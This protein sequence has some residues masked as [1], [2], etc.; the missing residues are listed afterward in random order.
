[1]EIPL[2]EFPLFFVNPNGVILSW[3]TAVKLLFGYEDDEVIGKHIGMLYK[4]T[5]NE[6]SVTESLQNA[7]G[8]G[9]CLAEVSQVKKNGMVL[10]AAVNYVSV[11]INETELIGLTVVIQPLD[12]NYGIKPFQQKTGVTPPG[13]IITGNI[14]FKK[15]IENSHEGYTLLDADFKIIYRSKSA[16]RIN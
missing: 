3:G 9:T 7:A 6:A 11:Y 15:L 12:G 4:D 8:R 14:S 2:Q 10:K 16:S 5:G 1:M 13:A